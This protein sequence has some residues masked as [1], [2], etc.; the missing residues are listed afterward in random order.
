[1]IDASIGV[2][3]FQFVHNFAINMTFW[4]INN[5]FTD[6]I[7]LFPPTDWQSLHWPYATHY[8]HLDSRYGMNGAY[9]AH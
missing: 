5:Y 8:T 3:D 1:M 6:E 7:T 4:N 9:L 2:I